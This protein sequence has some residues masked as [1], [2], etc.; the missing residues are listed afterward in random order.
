MKRCNVDCPQELQNLV[1]LPRESTVWNS[2]ELNAPT[3]PLKPPASQYFHSGY[4]SKGFIYKTAHIEWN[5][6]CAHR[7]LIY[8]SLSNFFLPVFPEYI[9]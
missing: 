2:L 5:V 8:C 1:L 6:H 4:D 3:E 7:A 9:N